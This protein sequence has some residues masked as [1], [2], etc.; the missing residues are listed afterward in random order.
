MLKSGS[1]RLPPRVNCCMRAAMKHAF[2]IAPIGG[3]PCSA[4]GLHDCLARRTA[5]EMDVMTNRCSRTIQR[6]G[7]QCRQAQQHSD[8]GEKCKRAQRHSGTELHE[9]RAGRTSS[10]RDRVATSRRPARGLALP[11]AAQAFKKTHKNKSNKCETKRKR[12]STIAAALPM[13]HALLQRAPASSLCQQASLCRSRGGL[14]IRAHCAL[15]SP[16]RL[17]RCMRS[18]RGAGAGVHGS[19]KLQTML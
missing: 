4:A 8:R 19:V 5:V 3:T 18:N 7:V 11:A 13:S 12:K 6:Q 15:R 1:V 10:R 17:L 9:Q 16:L 14:N 2:V